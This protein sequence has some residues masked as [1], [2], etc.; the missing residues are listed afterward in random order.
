ME[1]IRDKWIV[2]KEHINDGEMFTIGPLSDEEF[3]EV[4]ETMDSDFH[5]GCKIYSL[6]ADRPMNFKE[7]KRCFVDC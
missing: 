2:A 4:W 5:H 6:S 3:E 7:W 1:P